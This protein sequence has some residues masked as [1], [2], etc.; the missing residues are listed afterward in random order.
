MSVPVNKSIF[1]AVDL[2]T[3]GLEVDQGAAIV[4]IGAVKFSMD[5]DLGTFQSLIN[6]ETVIPQEVIRIHGITNDMVRNQPAINAA[7]PEFFRFA[8]DA[9][10]VAHNA[11]FDL[12]FLRAALDRINIPVRDRPVLDT[13]MLSRL[14]FPHLGQFRLGHV[15]AALSIETGRQHRAVDDAS[16][17]MQIFRKCVTV[18]GGADRLTM[19]DLMQRSGPALSLLGGE[20][21]GDP[22]IAMIETVIRRHGRVEIVYRKSA[23]D[24]ASRVITPFRVIRSGGVISV[25]AFCHMR[26]QERTFRMDR[27]TRITPL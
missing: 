18:L 8:G 14:V 25:R 15:A 16:A 5:H 17:S 26:N 11:P 6:P 9:I 1:V 7:L 3:T 27:I 12:S 23:A 10:L 19:D 13:C 20:E 2:E 22:R 24:A 4:E 21:T